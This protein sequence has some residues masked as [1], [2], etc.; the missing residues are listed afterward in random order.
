[1]GSYA[2]W[3]VETNRDFQEFPGISNLAPAT[4]YERRERG[5]YE[6]LCATEYD[7]QTFE[8]HRTFLFG[9]FWWP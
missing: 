4:T 1:M 2:F 8:K 3:G 6:F 7:F 9:N 5:A